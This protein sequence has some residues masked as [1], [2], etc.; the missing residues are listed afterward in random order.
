MRK[1]QKK[2]LLDCMDSLREAHKEIKE[3][4][5]KKE[6]AA[7]NNMLADCQE[8]AIAIGESIE[9][10]E[11]A[12][13]VTVSFVEEYCEV[14]F[15]VSEEI[16]CNQQTGES[17]SGENNMNENRVC[18]I[19]NKRLIKIE[20]SIKNDITVRL[21]M[22]FFP[23]KA[24]MWDSL[25]SV[26]LAAKEDPNCDAYCV[27][28]PYYDL[29]PDQ[30]FGRMHYEG[31]VYP[32]GI[33]IIDWEKYNFE[34]RRP[35]VIYIHNPY[36]GHNLVT[37][38]HPRYYSSNLKKYT[39]TLVYIP[40]YVTSGG[41]MEAQSMLSAYLYVDYIVIQSPQFREQFNKNIPDE[42][43]L[44]FGSP[45][46]DKVINK[47]MNP[48]EPPTG[49]IHE[50]T[51]KDGRRR[52][53]IFYNTSISG[54]LAD[55]ENFLKKMEYVFKCFEGREDVCLLWR[56]HPLLETTFESLRVQYHQ[57]YEM[58]K[59]M[60][61][62]K[63]LGILDTTPDIESSIALSDAY[64]GDAG[65]SVTSLFG[66]A[67]KPMFILDNRIHSKPNADSWREKINI[68]VNFN[69]FEQDRFIVTQENKLYISEGAQYDYHYF[70][71]LS[72]NVNK[73]EYFPIYQIGEKKYACPTNAQDILVIGNEGVEKKISLKKEVV[74]G[75]E[76]IA[77]WKYEKFL[78]LL[79]LYY[80]AIVR[81]DTVTE[82][83][84]YYEDGVDIFVKD[85]EGEK[86]T[87]RSLLYYGMLYL[88]SPV[89]NV[90]CRLDIEN[91]KTQLI[92]IPIKSRCGCYEL[93]EY[94]NEIW[95]LPYT[96]KT[97]VRW[98]PQTGKTR[99]YEDFPEEFI[100]VNPG[101]NQACEELPF[102]S[103]AFCEDYL[104]LTPRLANMYL[105][106]NIHTGQ[107]TR[108]NPPFEDMTEK[109]KMVS[110]KGF[111]IQLQPED[112]RAWIKIYSNVNRRLY[113]V[114]MKTNESK[115]IK[116][117]V[118]IKEL[119]DQEVGFGEYS[120]TL[121]YACAESIFNSLDRFLDGTTLGSP[122]DK[123]KQLAVYRE[124][125]ANGDGSC[126]RKIYE[127]ITT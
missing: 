52:R 30:S 80:P 118:D 38:V 9:Q 55:T 70:C 89:D 20:N 98:N 64:I 8:L 81:F 48:P 24:S 21:E 91:G 54:M 66:V 69:A 115:E 36:D 77:A 60:F 82:E 19:L 90:V 83:C 92:T 109:N 96:G 124:I 95:I 62:E 73:V 27:P 71:N 22:A 94:M 99:E 3:S 42:K 28:I 123:E 63:G 56:P 25:E 44:P 120:E 100:C 110:N 122:F 51:G 2:E 108:W 15:R 47:C 4:V 37:S 18:K 74:A 26:Y 7:A 87:G 39:D 59:T 103:V 45:K 57:Y 31:D 88:A 49:W 79:P 11:G 46:I 5:Q 78:I 104:Y 97:I 105:R 72:D 117:K 17:D 58:L 114:N 13:Y 85:K 65:T 127:Y 12:G 125:A 1:N 10:S 41:M 75:R 102:S 43:F 116:I 93:A 86:I 23:Y 40:Y 119:E 34:D 106:L 6:Y 50:M 121:K 76:F 113:N 32:K 112:E 126:G 53:V 35:D 107:F 68:G 16:R 111:F 101:S 67:G 33:E 61:L 14:L 84:M 29:N